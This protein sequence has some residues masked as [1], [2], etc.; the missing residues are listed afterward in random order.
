[1]KTVQVFRTD[2]PDQDAAADIVLVL[3][4][5]YAHCSINFDMDDCDRILRIESPY[6]SV[7]DIAVQ[8]LLAG[9]GYHCEPLQD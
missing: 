7:E 1:M 8:S 4:E 3:K 5:C 9:Y 6:E 2:V